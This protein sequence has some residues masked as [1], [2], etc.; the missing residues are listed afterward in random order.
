VVRL[1]A[2]AT[3]GRIGPDDE[4]NFPRAVAAL[5]HAELRALGERYLAETRIQRKTD[6]PFF[7]DK[8]PNNCLYVG[9]IHL[10]LPNARI[11]DARRHP[12]GCCF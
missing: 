2:R 10:I 7:I 3:A 12:L 8:M 1:L 11:I 6:A 5:A 4:A 9:L